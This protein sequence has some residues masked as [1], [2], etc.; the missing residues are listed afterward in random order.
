MHERVFVFTLVLHIA[1]LLF[2][3]AS[4]NNW[5]RF[6]SRYFRKFCV[7][8]GLCCCAVCTQSVEHLGWQMIDMLEI[9]AIHHCLIDVRAQFFNR[10]PF[11]QT[12]SHLLILKLILLQNRTEPTES[13]FSS[14]LKLRMV[15]ASDLMRICRMTCVMVR[16][17]LSVHAGRRRQHQ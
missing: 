6:F 17:K 13:C 8:F 11:A 12:I 16:L 3:L 15:L 2:C 1:Q 7:K 10:M 5:N 14:S 9:V 4:L